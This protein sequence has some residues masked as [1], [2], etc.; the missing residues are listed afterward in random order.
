MSEGYTCF[1]LNLHATLLT[2]LLAGICCAGNPELIKQIVLMVL[3][4]K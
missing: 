4:A 2:T 3:N 1:L